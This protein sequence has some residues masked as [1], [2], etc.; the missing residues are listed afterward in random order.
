MLGAR[1]PYVASNSAAS[2]LE[3]ELSE[4]HLKDARAVVRTARAAV[5][6][7][8]VS[9]IVTHNASAVLP[10]AAAARIFSPKEV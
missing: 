6:A 10:A 8:S 2:V 4:R 1:D 7:I 3:A 9:G 5:S